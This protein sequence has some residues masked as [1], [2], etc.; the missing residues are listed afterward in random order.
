[1]TSL[2]KSVGVCCAIVL[3]S[4]CVSTRY[5]ISSESRYWTCKYEEKLRVM[6]EPP[7]AKVY[8]EGSKTDYIGESPVETTLDAGEFRVTQTGTYRQQYQF[9][10]FWG[11]STGFQ[12]VGDTDWSDT[13]QASPTGGG[14]TVRAFLE[15]YKPAETR[16]E[17]G[18]TDAFWRAVKELKVAENGRLQTLVTGHNSI[19]LTLEP[20]PSHSRAAKDQQQQQQQQQQ[21]TVVIPG[22]Q[23]E[24]AQMGTVMV[25]SNV[26]GAD[27][28]VDGVFVGNT[29]A[30]LKLKDGIHIIEV[31]KSGYSTYRK[32]LRV[33]G[34]SELSLRAEL[35][36]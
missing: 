20:L 24:T 19:L 16:L 1:M 27:V 4:G 11:T 6:T 28:Y 5:K 25:S 26:Q 23:G 9:N 22:G 17:F 2:L 8:V 29:P 36:K 21:Q 34:G 13:L 15:G 35:T 12:K 14:W 18:K 31:K 10:E 32:E 7:G 33:F 3:F 30:N